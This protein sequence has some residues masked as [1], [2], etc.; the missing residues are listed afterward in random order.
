MIKKF[1]IPV[2][3]L[4]AAI[5]LFVMY[6]RQHQLYV[7]KTQ[8]ISQL[9]TEINQLQ[10][11]NTALQQSIRKMQQARAASELLQ[12]TFI[13]QQKYYRQ[14]WKNYIRLSVN[15]YQTGFLGGINNIKI[16]ISNQTDYAIDEV[17]AIVRYFR[18]NGQLFKTENIRFG[19][20]PPQKSRRITAPDS[21]RGMSIKAHITRITS[22]SM[23]FCWWEGKKVTAGN[24]DP[25]RCAGN[26][27]K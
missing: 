22:R 20:I 3:F 14:N 5:I 13:D 18:A 1:I 17:T 27:P 25:Y 24:D 7:E 23:N 4:A 10:N 21:R 9:T 12:P 2:I 8:L 6:R 16:K 26:E 19:N 11:Q 15:D